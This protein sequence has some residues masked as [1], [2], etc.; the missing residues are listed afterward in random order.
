MNVFS[1]C[2]DYHVNICLQPGFDARQLSVLVDGDFHQEKGE[3]ENWSVLIFST[4]TLLFWGF[5]HAG[6]ADHNLLNIFFIKVQ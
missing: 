6:T 1:L 3:K 2:I 4:M 5:L